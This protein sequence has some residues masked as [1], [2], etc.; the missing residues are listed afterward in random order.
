MVTT[1]KPETPSKPAPSEEKRST[2]SETEKLSRAWRSLV[3]SIVVT[4]RAADKL[5][6]RPDTNAK[7]L[8]DAVDQT[9]RARQD[10]RRFV[11]TIEAKLLGQ[12][13][14]TEA[15]AGLLQSQPRVGH[16]RKLRDAENG[17]HDETNPQVT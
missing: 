12:A 11:T 6:T 8:E 17:S 15:L 10:F 5:A 4:T 13:K 9:L 16:K 1:Q 14:E 7:E 2:T 3:S